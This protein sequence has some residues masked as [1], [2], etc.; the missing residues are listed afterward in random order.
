MV[1]SSATDPTVND[2]VSDRDMSNHT[3]AS[4]WEELPCGIYSIHMK[5]IGKYGARMKERWIVEV[6]THKWMASSLNELIKWERKLTVP[7]MENNSVYRGNHQLSQS[8]IR[9]REAGETTNN[10]ITKADLLSDSSLC[11]ANCITQSGT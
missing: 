7:T 2:F 8:F 4:Y 5:D 3:G 1:F 9:S 6:N 10:G 11:E